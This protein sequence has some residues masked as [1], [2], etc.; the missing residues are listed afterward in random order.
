[1]EAIEVIVQDQVNVTATTGFSVEERKKKRGGTSRLFALTRPTKAK[2]IVMYPPCSPQPL[3]LLSQGAAKIPYMGNNHPFP[4]KD[5]G[6]NCITQ[7]TKGFFDTQRMF[8]G[9]LKKEKLW[10]A[11]ISAQ[12][13]V[14]KSSPPERFGLLSVCSVLHYERRK[15]TLQ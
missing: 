10:F 15:H 13:E 5:P 3:I 14:W 12:T 4:L 8:Q 11:Q 2:N 6:L 7:M 1:M 9:L